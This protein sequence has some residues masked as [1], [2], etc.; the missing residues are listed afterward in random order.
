[1][2]FLYDRRTH[3]KDPKSLEQPG[4]VDFQ[5]GRGT[6]LLGWTQNGLISVGFI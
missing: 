4:L 5:V 3:S 2:K 6:M 1:M